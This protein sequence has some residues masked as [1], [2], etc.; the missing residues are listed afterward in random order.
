MRQGVGG[1]RRRLEVAQ[2]LLE[3][4]AVGDVLLPAGEVADAASTPQAK[5]KVPAVRLWNRQ[6]ML[7]RHG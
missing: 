1:R 5:M 3:A 7:H 4:L 2:Q 6:P